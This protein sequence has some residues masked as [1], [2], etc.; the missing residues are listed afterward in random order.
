MKLKLSALLTISSFLFVGCSSTD[1]RI[2]L[3]Q[4]GSMD[5][6]PQSTVKEMVDNFVDSPKWSALVADDGKD[7]VNVEGKIEYMEQP[8]D[9]LVQFNIDEKKETFEMNY[10]GINEISQDIFMQAL[11]IEEMCAVS[12]K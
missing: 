8:V 9:M 6:C 2:S 1:S 4:N 7:Y 10:F 3:V 12:S 11:L 5:Y